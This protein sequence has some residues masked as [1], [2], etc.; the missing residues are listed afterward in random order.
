MPKLTHPHRGARD[1]LVKVLFARGYS[2]LL[3]ETRIDV[4]VSTRDVALVNGTIEVRSK[5][6]II[7]IPIALITERGRRQRPLAKNQDK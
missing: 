4:L 1:K 2:G 7:K 3:A 5:G 6:L